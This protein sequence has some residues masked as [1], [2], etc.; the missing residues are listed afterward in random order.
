MTIL[1][2]K[3]S[4]D[5]MKVAC[6]NTHTDSL[7]FSLDAHADAVTGNDGWTLI[8]ERVILIIVE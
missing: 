8:M 5:Q 3:V 4:T 2:L 7:L 6:I 1:S